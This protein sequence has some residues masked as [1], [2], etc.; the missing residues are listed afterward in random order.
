MAESTVSEATG[1]RRR[2]AAGAT[3]QTPL[4]V[5]EEYFETVCGGLMV[6]E[7]AMMRMPDAPWFGVLRV[8]GLFTM[9]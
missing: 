3:L 7:R 5:S 1:Q 6:W 9:L 2:R 4:G 8:L